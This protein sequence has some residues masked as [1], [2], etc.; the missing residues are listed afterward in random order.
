MIF[1]Q[2]DTDIGFDGFPVTQQ[3]DDDDLLKPD[4]NFSYPVHKRKPKNTPVMHSRK[5]V[6]NK[7]WYL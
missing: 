3:D 4:P 1:V 6:E 5:P 2:E 7:G